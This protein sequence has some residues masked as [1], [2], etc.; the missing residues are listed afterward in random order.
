MMFWQQ[1]LIQSV[2][3]IPSVARLLISIIQIVLLF[4]ASRISIRVLYHLVSK[5][6]NSK[7]MRADERRR[8]TMISLL[9]N[10]IRYAVYFIYILM[11]LQILGFHIETL[12]AGAGIAGVA[13]GFGAQSLIKDVLTG[14]FILFEDQYGVGDSVQINQFS[15]TVIHIGLRITRVQAWTG[16]IEII[17]NGQITTVT[18]YSKS[19]SIAV[20]DISVSYDTDIPYAT[21][22]MKSVMDQ[23]KN[24]N[25]N[26]VGSVAVLGVLSLNASDISLRATAE[27]VPTKQSG[28]ERMA[29]QKIKE[30]FDREKIEMPY[31]QTVVWMKTANID[32]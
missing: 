28:V 18:N 12:L 8:N 5:F 2:K 25:E 29:R 15:G 11:T 20:I 22:V 21:A 19:N 4:I 9:H 13:I 24:E 31:P 26:I 23:L 27:C 32:N 6:L 30:A 17:P 10:I 7:A 14:F 16:E 1:M 3:D